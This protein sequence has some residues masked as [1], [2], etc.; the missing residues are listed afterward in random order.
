MCWFF[1]LATLLFLLLTGTSAVAATPVTVGM[2]QFPPLVYTDENG[3]H[4]G[5]F[6]DLIREIAGRCLGP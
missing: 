5:L 2:F 6:M 1:R 4:T 3:E